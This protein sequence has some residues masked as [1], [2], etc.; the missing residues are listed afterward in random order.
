M[1]EV[2][3]PLEIKPETAIAQNRC[4]AQPFFNLMNKDCFLAIK[5]IPNNSVDL[6]VTDPP[7]GINFTKG[8]KSGSTELVHGDD[9]FSVM[10]FVDELMREF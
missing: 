9:G 5:E 10:V 4:Y 6:I 1:I 8:Y 2:Q 7:Y 3:N